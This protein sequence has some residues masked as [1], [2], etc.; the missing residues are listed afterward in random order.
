MKKFTLIPRS[1]RRDQ[2][3][4]KNKVATEKRV[5]PHESLNLYSV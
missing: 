1:H 2:K 5:S 3:L 4:T